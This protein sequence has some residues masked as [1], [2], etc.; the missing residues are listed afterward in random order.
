MKKLIVISAALLLCSVTSSFAQK[1]FMVSSE[2]IFKSLAEYNQAIET[3]DKMEAQYIENIENAYE[4]IEEQ[5]N[6]YKE[7]ANFLS[8]SNRSLKEAQIIENEKKVTEYQ[9]KTLG[10]NGDL[11]KKRIEL[12][13]PI[14]EKVFGVIETYAQSQGYDMV[15]DIATT[16]SIIYYKPE[17]D[18]TNEIIESLKTK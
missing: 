2:E 13:Q 6:T 16:P 9:E 7:Q 18:K 10:D 1:Y 12:I 14:Q 11:I 15:I 5:Y 3:L 4:L 17:L 8:E